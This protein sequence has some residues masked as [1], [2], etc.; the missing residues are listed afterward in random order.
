MNLQELREKR[1]KVLDSMKNFLQMH[2]EENGTLS[3]ENSA[4][5]DKME[6]DLGNLGNEIKRMERLEQVENQLSV[7]TSMALTSQPSTQNVEKTGRASN[8]YKEAM[9]TAFRTDFNKI[10]NALRVGVDTEGGYL[11]PEEMDHRL[12]EE[13]EGNN[14]MRS[15]S[16][17]IKTQGE[18]KINLV[19]S[20]PVAAWLD[21]GETLEFSKV[22]FGQKLLDA[23]KMGVAIQ[24]T[25]ELLYDS[26]FDLESYINKSFGQALA[27]KEEEAFLI[28]DGEGKKP[29]GIFQGTDGGEINICTGGNLTGDELIKLVYKLKRQYRRKAAFII[30][31]SVIA[32]IRLMKDNDGQYLWQPALVGGEPDKLLGY[33]VY[34]SQF[35][36]TTA[37]AFGDFSYYN[38]GDRGTR[39]F[40]QLS[41]KFAMEGMIGYVVKE[42]IDGLLVLK[43]AVQILVFND[44]ASV[45]SVADVADVPDVPDN[46]H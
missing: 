45:S 27:D 38:I 16:T 19:T 4:T 3:V 41:E 29:T 8:E 35:A 14:I 1:S 28:G 12:I 11:V 42:R 37:I 46:S 25:E 40:Q 13:L 9:L 26:A 34:T 21:E 6:A 36:P 32:S 31:D 23:H 7:P 20:K 22:E 39:S 24:I 18:R 44:T 43:E 17:V 15:L 10:E 30:N 5:Y 2:R 33:P